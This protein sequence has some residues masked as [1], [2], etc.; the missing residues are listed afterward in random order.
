M[1]VLALGR[2]EKP[3]VQFLKSTSR[4]SD[5]VIS[6][7]LSLACDEAAENSRHRFDLGAYNASQITQL[8]FSRRNRRLEA[9][10]AVESNIDATLSRRRIADKIR[11]QGGT[12]NTEISVVAEKYVQESRLER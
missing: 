4:I 3:E 1:G 6:T 9:P 10:S 2:F 11:L 5:C 8:K 7:V 12:V